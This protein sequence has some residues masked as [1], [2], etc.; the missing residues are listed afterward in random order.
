VVGKPHDIKGE[1]VFAYVVLKGRRP[2]GSEA[3]KLIGELRNW[4]GEQ[5][6]PIAKPDD[7]RLADNLP[8]TRSGKI[9]R[10]LLRAVARGEDITQDISTLEN[11][12]I[13]EQLRGEDSGG[14]ADKPKKSAMNAK[15]KA[16]PKT[17]APKAK[18]KAKVSAKAK[19]KANT[20]PKVIAKVEPK[21]KPKTKS[22]A[23][24]APKRKSAPKKTAR[25][26]KA[27]RKK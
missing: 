20:K 16:K 15:P 21:A 7:I 14:G 19:P 13:I 26:S 2:Q 9:M 4:V 5:L 11:P 18:A 27:R 24:A 22:K 3:A 23:K 10:R 25:K 6:S 8:K 17:P 12:A 1:S